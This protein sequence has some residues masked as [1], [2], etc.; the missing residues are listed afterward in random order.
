LDC[1][2]YRADE[3]YEEERACQFDADELLG[4]QVP[5]HVGDVLVVEDASGRLAS[6]L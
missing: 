1:D 6:V 3:S 4:E 5:P 2:R